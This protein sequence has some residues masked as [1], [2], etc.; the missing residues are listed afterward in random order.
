MKL[1]ESILLELSKEVFFINDDGLPRFCGVSINI[2]NRHAPRKRKLARGNQMSFITKDT[3]KAI[4]KRSWL[5]SKF[6]QNKTRENKTLY[7]KQRKYCVLLFRKR[8]P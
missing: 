1:I 7:T 6:V 8:Y 3:S 2:L 5:R 4:M